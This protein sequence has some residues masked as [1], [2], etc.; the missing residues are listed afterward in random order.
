[1]KWINIKNEQPE[2]IQ[3]NVVL[4][5]NGYYLFECEFDDGD[6]CSMGGDEM[7]HWMPLPPPPED[8]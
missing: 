3:G 8:V 1:M 5:H 4:G 7:T 2:Q 6:W